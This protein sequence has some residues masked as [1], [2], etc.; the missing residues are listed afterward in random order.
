[1]MDVV[2]KGIAIAL[3]NMMFGATVG[4][5][6]IMVREVANLARESGTNRRKKYGKE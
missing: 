4:A 1:M 6:Y 3:W 2:K 5:G